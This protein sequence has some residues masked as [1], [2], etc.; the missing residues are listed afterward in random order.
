M[1]DD[2][3]FD[4]RFSK[5]RKTKQRNALI[6]S[7]VRVVFIGHFPHADFGLL[8]HFSVFTLFGNRWKIVPFL[9]E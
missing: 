9:R 4:S 6:S 1:K 7:L 8:V 2:S 3:L 5:E